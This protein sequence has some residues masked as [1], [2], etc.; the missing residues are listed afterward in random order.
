MVATS[1]LAEQLAWH[2][3][4]ELLVGD[5]PDQ[6]ARQC[7]RLNTDSNEWNRIRGNALAKVR[8]EC[9]ADRFDRTLH[10]LMESSAEQAR[11]RQASV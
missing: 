5:T 7:L 2:D 10:E 6:F 3:E 8:E 9:S 11:R 4:Q 1:L